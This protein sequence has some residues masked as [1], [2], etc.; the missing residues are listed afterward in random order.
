M[1]WNVGGQLPNLQTNA[2]LKCG[3]SHGLIMT[4]SDRSNPG[5]KIS[6][7]IYIV[8]INLTTLEEAAVE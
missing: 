8:A 5:F 3:P 1:P 6:T 7:I 4:Y 2:D